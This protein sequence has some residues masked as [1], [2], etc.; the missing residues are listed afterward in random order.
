MYGLK[1]P[2][3]DLNCL[4]YPAFGLKCLNLTRHLRVKTIK[5]TAL[6]IIV[7]QGGGDG[8]GYRNMWYVKN[9]PG[10]GLESRWLA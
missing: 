5:I 9:I 4:K 6:D 8:R 2:V 7:F 3:F 1:Y 10:V